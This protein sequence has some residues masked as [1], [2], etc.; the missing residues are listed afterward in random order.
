MDLP[1]KLNFDGVA[2]GNLG[3]MGAGC[4]IRDQAGAMHLG[5]LKKFRGVY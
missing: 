1:W 3:A 2:K 5:S 4:I